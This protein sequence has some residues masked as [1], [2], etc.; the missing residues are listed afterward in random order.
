MFVFQKNNQ[1]SD[2][3]KT[4]PVGVMLLQAGGWTDARDEVNSRF[5]QFCENAL[6]K[7]QRQTTITD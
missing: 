6:K 1:I 5:E 2:L 3:E 7:E 4:R